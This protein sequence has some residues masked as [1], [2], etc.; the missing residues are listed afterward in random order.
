MLRSSDYKLSFI[1][2]MLR[3]S[4]YKLSF[5]CNL[6]RSSDYKLF[7]IC[8]LLRSSDYKLLFV[9]CWQVVQAWKLSW[10]FVVFLLVEWPEDRIYQFEYRTNMYKHICPK[11]RLFGYNSEK[12]STLHSLV[13]THVCLLAF[14]QMYASCAVKQADEQAPAVICLSSLVDGEANL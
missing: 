4:D 9:P 6:L 8:N 14:A 12:A 1:C 5:I 2:N 3:S 7:F 11:E 10:L 13:W